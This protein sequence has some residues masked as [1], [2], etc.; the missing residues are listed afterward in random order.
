MI[1]LD[2][3]LALYSRDA[4][5]EDL[6]RK[7]LAG[8]TGVTHYVLGRN[9][10]ALNIAHRTKIDGVVDDFAPPN[11][12]WNGM[13]IVRADMLPAGAV[14]VNCSMSIRPISAQ[15]RLES[16]PGIRVLS[17]ADFVRADQTFPL[18]DFVAAF[19]Y[20]YGENQAEWQALASRL[21]DEESRRVLNAV[22]Q[23]R[24][25]GDYRCMAGFSV[26][27]EEQYFDPV[28]QLSNTEVFVDCGGFDGDTVFEF[29]ARARDYEHIYMFEPSSRNFEKASKRL[30]DVPRITLMP[31]GVSDDNGSLSF[32]PEAGSASS[33]NASGSTKIDVVTLD[34]SIGR[35]VTF[36][37]MDLEGWE[38]NALKGAK[39]HI[40]E[41]Y[42]KLA[43][44]VYHSAADFWR[45][46]EFVLGLRDNYEIYLRHYSEGWSETIMY[47]IPAHTRKLKWVSMRQ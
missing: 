47:F 27:F 11:E 26:R 30:R 1:E 42:P 18:P 44:A 33:V 25:T 10:H 2:S 19:R 21:G 37:K 28:V 29:C 22:M 24:Y 23:Y 34:Q 12:S 38:L 32:D 20:E 6:A 40:L 17:Y 4:L 43:I 3:P 31:V 46:P 13:P 35:R 14:V 39:R 8:T 5:C 41:D 16:I 15:A 7:C 36:I 45:I 9:Q